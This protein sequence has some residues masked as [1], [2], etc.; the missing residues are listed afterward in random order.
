[1]SEIVRKGVDFEHQYHFY[2]IIRDEFD[3]TV[4]VK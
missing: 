1:M 2:T 4:N 3:I